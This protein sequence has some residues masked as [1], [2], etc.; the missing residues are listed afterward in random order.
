MPVLM[1]WWW[2]EHLGSYWVCRS[3]GAIGSPATVLVTGKG[4]PRGGQRTV[5][6]LG[7][8]GFWWYSRG[9]RHSWDGVVDFR[10]LGP[11]EVAQDGQSLRLGGAQQRALLAVLLIHRGEVLSTDRLID[12]L[13]ADRPPPTAAKTVQGYVSQLRRVLG[14]EA[15]VTRGHGY[16][17]AVVSDQV[18][19]ARFEALV[20]GG[21]GRPG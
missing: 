2:W 21:S 10:I 9:G 15:I 19:V 4:P 7:T 1:W 16:L 13:W 20:E 6:R 11:L 12:E 3:P 14:E 17:L 8:A 18:D 5:R